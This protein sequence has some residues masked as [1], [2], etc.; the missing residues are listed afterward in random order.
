MVADTSASRP[1]YSDLSNYNAASIE[2]LHGLDPVRKRPGMYTDVSTPN[3]L[4]QEV[5]DNSVDE[6]LAGTCRFIRVQL[7]ADGWIEVED[8]GRGMPI[9]IHPEQGRPGVEV[10]M[11]T[12]HAGAKFSRRTYS[13]SGGLHGVGVSVV[14]ALSERLEVRIRR[15]GEH[16]CAFEQ[17]DLVEPLSQSAAKPPRGTQGT[18][19]RFKPEA[20]YFHSTSVDVSRIAHLMRAK[21]V[22][23][24]GLELR[25]ID[26]RTGREERWRYEKGLAGYLDEHI[27]QANRLPQQLFCGEFSSSAED[28]NQ[29]VEWALCW[30]LGE[31]ER[32][33]ESYA[34]LL[35]TPD[36]G[37]H[38]NGLRTGVSEAVREFCSLRNLVSKGVKLTPEDVF[39]NLNYVLSLKLENPEF[40]GQTK[41][42]LTTRNSQTFVAAAV[43]DTFS[44]WLNAHTA[45][46]EEICSHIV[47]NAQER[48]R[49][50]QASKRKRTLGGPTLPGKLVDCSSTNIE[51]TE[52]FIVEGDSAGGSAKQARDRHFQA[53]LPLRGKILNS[54]EVDSGRALASQEIRDL[55]ASIGIEPGT[56][57]IEGLR[58]G[59][60]CILA[61]ADADG[62]HISSLLCALFIRHFPQLVRGGHICVALPPL[63]RVDCGK[64]VFYARDNNEKDKIIGELE[65][66]P[67]RAQ[68]QITRFKGLGEMDPPQLR[69]TVMKPGRRQLARLHV[70][71]DEAA[72]NLLDMLLNKKRAADRRAWLSERGVD[73]DIAL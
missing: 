29:Q 59:K 60:I 28:G 40:I 17:G 5:L 50:A 8:D 13:Y 33:C 66:R 72:T 55:S 68:I 11:L 57:D 14:N 38:M 51:E 35:P 43:K 67:R 71:D 23:C 19:I 45:T 32:L 69:E 4:L 47:Q 30:T 25:F 20:S 54:W 10:I 73:A 46:A 2:V 61:D 21:A 44:L 18:L 36:G 48:M 42:R 15:G 12:L 3:H 9:D 34:N 41:E 31:R 58:Y 1:L 26:E 27:E 52:I 16:H 53:V 24:P 22:L 37:T 49:A 56:G 70:D 63:F 62:A 65:A 6:A 39:R 7:C 64:E